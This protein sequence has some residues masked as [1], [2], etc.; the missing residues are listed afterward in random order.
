MKILNFPFS[1]FYIYFN[2][3]IY[4]SLSKPKVIKMN[5]GYID[6][7]NRREDIL[8]ELG[9]YR[10]IK[11]KEDWEK[12]LEILRNSVA[13]RLNSDSD[14][15]SKSEEILKEIKDK[16]DT[17]NRFSI[18]AVVLYISHYLENKPISIKKLREELGISEITVRKTLPNISEAL[19]ERK[20][21][22]FEKNR[23]N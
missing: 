22:V 15:K 20:R 13:E 9:E 16:V 23:L 18:A 3:L 1:Y 4:P 10:K 11:S 8:E 12:G 6:L 19:D 2:S 17:Y 14:V 21:R 7:K 5:E